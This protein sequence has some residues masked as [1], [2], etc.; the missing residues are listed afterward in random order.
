[1]NKKDNKHYC[2]TGNVRGDQ[3]ERMFKNGFFFPNLKNYNFLTGYFDKQYT[4][5]GAVKNRARMLASVELNPNNIVYN[6]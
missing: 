5:E 2:T 1:M 4:S 3:A 6:G